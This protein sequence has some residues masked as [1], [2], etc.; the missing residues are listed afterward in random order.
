MKCKHD[1]GWVAIANQILFISDTGKVRLGLAQNNQNKV[2]VVCNIPKC[3]RE[4]NIY[5]KAKVKKW[6]N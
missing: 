1:Y 5:I 6:G 3:S 2:R 4:R